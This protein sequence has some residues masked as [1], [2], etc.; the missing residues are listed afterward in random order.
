MLELHS[1]QYL[2]PFWPRIPKVGSLRIICSLIKGITFLY[3]LYDSRA[4][5]NRL[6]QVGSKTS[7]LIT[8]A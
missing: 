1:K 4:E 7:V 2:D 3:C 5:I 6:F 8:V